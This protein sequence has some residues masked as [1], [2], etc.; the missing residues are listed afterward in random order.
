MTVRNSLLLV[1]LVTCISYF[2]CSGQSVDPLTGQLQFS[3]PLMS[4]SAEGISI[5]VGL[6][7]HGNSM[8]VEENEGDFGLGWSLS[9]GGAVTRQLRGLPDDYTAS[10]DTRKG[11]LFNNNAQSAQSFTTTSDDNLSSCVDESADWTFLNGRNFMNDTEPDIFSFSAPGLSGRFILSADGTP[12]LLTWQDIAITV[13]RDAL[14]QKIVGFVIRNN[15][16]ITYNFLH[17][18]TSRIKSER[19]PALSNPSDTL[20]FRTTFGRFR[21]EIE[22]TSTWHLTSI[23]SIS[24]ASA[25]YS[26]TSGLQTHSSD[27]Y[28][29]IEPATTTAVDTLFF[30][31]QTSTPLYL[32]AINLRSFNVTINRFDNQVSR[33]HFYDAATGQEREYQF[34]Y[35]GLLPASYSYPIRSFNFLREIRQVSNCIPYPPFIFSYH[36]V[37]FD[38][39]I[40]SITWERGWGQD[41][42]GFFNGA[43]VNRNIPT[44]FYYSGESN[45]RRLR[46]TPIPGVTPTQTLTGQDRSVNTSFNLFGSLARI[47]Y[48]TGGYVEI[49]YE[50]H[51]YIDSST[52]EELFGGGV[53]VKSISS[54]G[55]DA[56][57]G[58]SS[59]GTGSWR[60]VKREYEYIQPGSSTS[61]GRLINPPVFG[62]AVGNNRILRTQNSQ[63]G[64]S[65]VLYT[66]VRER[67]PG[68]GYTLYEY[69][70]P[71]TYPQLN[72]QE[73]S[74]PK[75]KI[76]RLSSACANADGIQNGYYTYPYAP[77]TNFDFRRGLL[78]KRSEYQENGTLVRDVSYTYAA[79]SS[80]PITFKAARLELQDQIYHFSQYNVMSGYLP[81]VMQEVVRE[82]SQMNPALIS[83][84]TINYTYNP[85]FLIQTV[86]QTQPD[87]AVLQQKF[88]YS[89]DFSISTPAGADLPATALKLLNDQRRTAEP[90]EQIERYT[91]P[92]APTVI[93]KAT[94]TTYKAFAS[95]PVMPE[96]RWVLNTGAALT[97]ASSTASNFSYDSDYRIISIAEDYDSRYNLLNQTDGRGTREAYHYGLDHGV[98]V[99][100]FRNCRAAEAACESFEVYSGF[101]FTSS[102]GTGPGWTGEKSKLLTTAAPLTSHALVQ[103]ADNQYRFSIWVK[104][105][106][107]TN[108]TVTALNGPTVQATL[109]L[110]YSSSDV[111]QWKRLEAGWDITSVAASFVVRIQTSADAYVDDILLL[112]MAAR[113]VQTQTYL[114][115]SGTTSQ[116]DDQGNSAKNVF[117]TQGRLTHAF[118]R[119]RNLVQFNEYR[120][121]QEPIPSVTAAFT[122]SAS[123]FL[124]GQ[125]YTFNAVPNC[126]PVSYEWK[127]NGVVSGTSASLARSFT[128]PGGY[129]IEL[130]VSHTTYGYRI[131][132]ETICVE[133]NPVVI[134]TASGPNPFNCSNASKTFVVQVELTGCTHTYEWWVRPVSTG[135]WVKLTTLLQYNTATINYGSQGSYTLKVIVTTVCNTLKENPC[136]GASSVQRENAV[137][138]VYL[139]SGEPC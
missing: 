3:V 130:K 76:A 108:L 87:G 84:T 55:G 104:A 86:S 80:N 63:G 2:S 45:A 71:G 95:G 110:S 37:N 99:A 29:K 139:P 107:P 32:T 17:T 27:F 106:Q 64:P 34:V 70:L 1:V 119:Q 62:I 67:I 93:R 72:D 92:G 91:P 33:I 25:D 85:R 26:Y 89:G 121:L 46:L 28:S 66:A 132:S 75:S 127:V 134:L 103:K 137:E 20:L 77:S 100:T 114:P 4:V 74:V 131:Y 133:L 115:F 21:K 83:T 8:R 9:A 48:P 42:F 10:G 51:R 49:N 122:A 44:L 19:W 98:G 111:N 68:N 120:H 105:A 117:D 12:Q 135:S 79:S 36:L 18:V 22:Y 101:G 97:E 35:G 123:Q 13:N 116:T 39:G 54:Y 24:G 61:S 47:T 129:T 128:N 7:R 50:S 16:G 53:R 56:A 78:A 38:T 90:I 40:A 69:N 81:T 58:G 136:S 52:N 23:N 125:A 59:V 5:P 138:M 60:V 82:L 118:D 41:W 94:L 30:I 15:N 102:A 14:N 11:W 96:K 109:S 6:V 113:L 126:M 57:V 31:R 112:P 124:A 73:W 88:S 43:S 65:E